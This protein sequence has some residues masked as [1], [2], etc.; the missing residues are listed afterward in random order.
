MKPTGAPRALI[1]LVSRKWERE[2]PDERGARRRCE[3][4]R[5]PRLASL[6]TTMLLL[7][8]QDVLAVGLVS[9]APKRN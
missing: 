1:S 6:P 5:T 4:D 2:E 8:V 9:Q 3:F 7:S